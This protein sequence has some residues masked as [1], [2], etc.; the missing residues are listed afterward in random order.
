MIGYDGYFEEL[1]VKQRELG[2]K[3]ADGAFLEV[4]TM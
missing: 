1:L 3:I 2:A 4:F